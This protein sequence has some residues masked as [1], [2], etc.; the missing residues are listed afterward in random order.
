MTRLAVLLEDRKD[1][2]IERRILCQEQDSQENHETMLLHQA[3]KQRSRILVYIDA[4]AAAAV[5]ACFAQCGIDGCH[6]AGV[7]RIQ[8][9]A[10]I[11]EETNHVVPAP[12][13]GAVQRSLA[14]LAFAQI[15]FTAGF[16]KEIEGID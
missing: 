6:A 8:P 10:M 9:G 2:L 11:D 14:P 13:C 12:E 16:Q 5:A 4:L 7:F 1:V 15:D 3:S